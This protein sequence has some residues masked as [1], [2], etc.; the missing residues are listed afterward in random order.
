LSTGHRRHESSIRGHQREDD[1]GIYAVFV[2]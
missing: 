2:R 1:I